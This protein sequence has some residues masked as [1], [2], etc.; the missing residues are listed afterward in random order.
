[1]QPNRFAA[2]LVAVGLLLPV[3]NGQE[4]G[5]ADYQRRTLQSVIDAHSG[6]VQ[7][8]DY[9]LS[10]D[11]FPSQVELVY[12]GKTRRVSGKRMELLR[13]W[14]KMAK[15]PVSVVELFETEVLFRERAV[16]H[17]LP[18]QKPLIPALQKEVKLGETI[19]SYVIFMGGAKQENRWEWIFAMNEF[20]ASTRKAALH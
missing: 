19:N 16:E 12:L 3:C 20:D 6:G 7:R 9:L 14:E 5:W 11:S 18:V 17:W 15:R 13:K 8:L 2:A 10:A 4:G 1:M